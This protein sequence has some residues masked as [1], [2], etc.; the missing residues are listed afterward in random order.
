MTETEKIWAELA[1]LRTE[2]KTR[3]HYWV[4]WAIIL[5]VFAV[6]FALASPYVLNNNVV[7][8]GT[9]SSS[10]ASGSNAFGVITNGARIDFGAGASDYANSNGT[11]VSFA[12]PVTVTGA[13]TFAGTV[14]SLIGGNTGSTAEFLTF[15]G[16]GNFVGTLQLLGGAT[17]TGNPDTG[18]VL[19]NRATLGIADNMYQVRNG[20]SFSS[21]LVSYL[22]V[23][24]EFGSNSIKATPGRNIGTYSTIDT[25]TA[26]FF[27]SMMPAATVVGTPSVVLAQAGATRR[28]IQHASVAL[29]GNA[30]GIIG[31]YTT[32]RPLYRPKLTTVVVT[33]ATVNLEQAWIAIAE[34]TL[35]AVVEPTGSTAS[36]IDY[37]AV[38]FNTA[39]S[40]NWACC[41]GDGTNMSCSDVG[42]AVAAATEYTVSVDWTTVATLR[43]CVNN[44]CVDKTTLLS[45]AAVELGVH[46]TATTL[47]AA[48]AN[49]LVNSTILEQN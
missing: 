26:V 7:G 42:L 13:V 36:G 18:I 6:P 48:A 40:A 14:S 44:T 37:V 2:K 24:G 19:A 32:T 9:F 31:P 17:D 43:C 4:T 8:D 22:T 5:A 35:V 11:T 34:S 1:R 47:Q 39:V 45:T 12:G 15:G 16:S 27:P 46:N 38:A 49:W 10:I 28:Y 30:G 23:P 29:S 25:T 3:S 33:D 21:R 20:N 41:S